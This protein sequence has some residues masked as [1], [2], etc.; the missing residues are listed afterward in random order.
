M[1]TAITLT[2]EHTRLWTAIDRSRL[3]M[4][5]ETLKP[6]SDALWS[7]LGPMRMDIPAAMAAF[8]V[9]YA[10]AMAD[11]LMAL[12]SGDPISDPGRDDRVQAVA[13]YVKQLIEATVNSRRAKRFL[14]KAN[15]GIS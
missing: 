11:A 5:P 13:L 2:N 14:T 10:N 15:G 7:S 6:A 4:S 1:K 12:E 3:S 8:S 9:V